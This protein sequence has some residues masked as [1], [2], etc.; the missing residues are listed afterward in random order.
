MSEVGE[1]RAEVERLRSDPYKGQWKRKCLQAEAEL[2]V[3]KRLNGKW[4]DERTEAIIRAEQVEAER[5][6]L[7]VENERL[8]VD[9][10]NA[11]IEI[12]DAI[13]RAEGWLA[14]VRKRTDGMEPTLSDRLKNVDW[15]DVRKH[16]EEEQEGEA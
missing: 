6:A 10:H 2:T 11:L 15:D 9:L 7:R 16:Y 14:I 5:D 1:L 8:R 13:G 12:R 4:M 3:A